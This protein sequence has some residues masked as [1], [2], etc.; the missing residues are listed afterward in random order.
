MAAI[1]AFDEP[2]ATTRGE[3]VRVLAVGGVL[4]IGG[5]TLAELAAE[6]SSAPG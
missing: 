3:F 6:P 2:E 5:L 1:H 4:V